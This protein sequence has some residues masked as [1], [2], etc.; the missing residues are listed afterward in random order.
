MHCSGDPSRSHCRPE[1]TRCLKQSSKKA[2]TGFSHCYKRHGT[3]TLF[4][5]RDVLSGQVKVGHFKRR[6]RREFL[7]FMNDVIHDY[8][9]VEIHYPGVEIHVIL[10]NLNT[11]KPK[12]DHWLRLHPNVHFH[13][14]P[15][16]SSWLNQVECWFS[17]LSRRALKGAGYSAL[18]EQVRAAIDRFVKAYNHD[19]KPFEWRCQGRS[20]SRLGFCRAD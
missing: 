7:A 4:A 14:T 13:F 19:A 10:D 2:L 6:L 20:S 1:I 17:F 12:H 15:T 8:P 5:A 18:F 3:T 16:Y 11:H 9:G